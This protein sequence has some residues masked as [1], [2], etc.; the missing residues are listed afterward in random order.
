MSGRVVRLLAI[1]GISSGGKYVEDEA[2][3]S[4]FVGR[5]MEVVVEARVVVEA[6]DEVLVRRLADISIARP[7]R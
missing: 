4:R 5:V 2:V 6:H 7:P 1:N 3:S